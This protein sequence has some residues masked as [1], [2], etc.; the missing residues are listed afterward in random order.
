MRLSDVVSHAGLSI[1]AIVALVLFV[2]I[3]IAVVIRVVA[4]K[5]RD[6]ERNARLPLDDATPRSGDPDHD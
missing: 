3:F 5:R 1:Y 4:A 2:G 6:M